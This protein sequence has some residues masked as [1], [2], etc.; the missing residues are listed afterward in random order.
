V[1]M[2]QMWFTRP[3]SVVMQRQEGETTDVG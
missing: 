3:P 1:S 2:Y